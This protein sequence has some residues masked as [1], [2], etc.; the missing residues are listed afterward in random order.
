[1]RPVFNILLE[2]R[3]E[4]SEFHRTTFVVAGAFTNCTLDSAPEEELL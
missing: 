2:K 3:V 4:K 1:M